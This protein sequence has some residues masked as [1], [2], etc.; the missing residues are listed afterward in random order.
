MSKLRERVSRWFLKTAKK[1][2]EKTFSDEMTT[3]HLPQVDTGIDITS[4]DKNNV[5]KIRGVYS[6]SSMEI[7]ALKRIVNLDFEKEIHYRISQGITEEIMKKYG[8]QI[9]MEYKPELDATVY[10]L[11]IYLCKPQKKK[12]GI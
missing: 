10:S 7:E 12:G 9:K 3:V 2:D 11:D 5:D 4:Y 8:D 6:L 1:I